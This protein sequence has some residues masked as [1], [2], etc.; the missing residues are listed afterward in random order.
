MLNSAI[1]KISNKKINEC[2]REY[3]HLQKN[4]EKSLNSYYLIKSEINNP[5]TIISD[6][7]ID[8][9][10]ENIK[11]Y[12]ALI[13]HL[14]TQI[15]SL[16]DGSLL[17]QIFSIID[18]KVKKLNY[19]DKTKYSS[20][21]KEH[22]DLIHH[23]LESKPDS[24]LYK[25]SHLEK[26]FSQ[27]FH[28]DIRCFSYLLIKHFEELK[29]LFDKRSNENLYIFISFINFYSKT[30]RLETSCIIKEDTN[31]DFE[32]PY[33]LNLVD[34]TIKQNTLIK[35]TEHKI[36]QQNTLL[37]NMG[38]SKTL[39]K[40]NKQFEWL[41]LKRNEKLIHLALTLEGEL[42]KNLMFDFSELDFSSLNENDYN[43]ILLSIMC[44]N[45]IDEKNNTL[46]S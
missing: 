35:K 14:Y 22:K 4:L 45:Y 17:E 34:S 40:I 27:I 25:S 24:D 3:F 41:L 13:N 15:Y 42:K 16:E 28:L 2:L 26:L 5:N 9:Y 39:N 1:R 36:I 18:S 33:C 31:H 21:P 30:L 23:I 20:L 44:K 46:L 12:D 32:Q 10:N 7:I 43:Q 38:G 37:D 11:Y 8:D 6:E 29:D 19:H